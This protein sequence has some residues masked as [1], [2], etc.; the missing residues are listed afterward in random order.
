MRRPLGRFGVLLLLGVAGVPACDMAERGRDGPP[1]QRSAESEAAPSRGL[2]SLLLARAH[3]RADSL[4]PL[5]SLLIARH[6]EL[7]REWYFHGA[8]ADEPA[9]LKSASKSVLSALV[10][11]AIAEGEL[12]GPD[13]PVAG[14]F[15]EELPADADPRL[16]SVT[17]G[18]LLSMR[19]GLRSTSFANYGAWVTSP[20]WVRHVLSRPFVDEPGGGMVYSTG[21]THLLSAILTRATGA[22][23]RAYAD[24]HLAG[25]LGFE[26]P[27]WPRDPQGIY[28]GGNDMRMRPRDLLRFGELYRN[29]GRHDGRQV[30]PAEWIETSWRRRTRSPW[31][32]NGYG[33]GWWTRRFAGYD[34]WFAWGYGGQYLFIVPALELTV[35][36][37]SDP[38]PNLE[39]RGH[40][41]AQMELL[42]LYIIP[43]AERGAGGT[44]S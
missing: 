22:S 26:L 35:V 5:R 21:S 44:A 2:D 17:I 18:H 6:G 19:S 30:V 1:R 31:N 42:T 32:G 27:G 20:N 3:V 11:I 40:R 33:Y 8:A 29:G 43:A 14:F 28:F 34:T 10:G 38:S 24:E 13:Q 12:A 39:R 15:E 9:N 4:S 7:A 36:M 41:R 16:R 37:T 25:P 23:T